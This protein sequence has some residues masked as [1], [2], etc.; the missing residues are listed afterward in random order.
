MST[1]IEWC[2]NQDGT[3]GITWNP[4]TGCTPC[5]PSCQN[6]Y[7]RPMATRLQAMGVKKYAKGFNVT[8]HENV[9]LPK[10]KKPKTIF[11]CSMSDLFHEDVPFEFIRRVFNDI[12]AELLPLSGYEYTGPDHRFIILTKRPGR[13][14][15][16]WNWHKEKYSIYPNGHFINEHDVVPDRRICVGVTVEDQE[17]TSRIR[18]LLQV[19]AE[20]HFVSVEPMLGPIIFEKQWLKIAT[21]GQW[22][23]VVECGKSQSSQYLNWI[24]M[25]A[26][27]GPGRRP[28][29]FEW[30]KD[31]VRQ[32]Q[33][34]NVPLFYKQGPND[35]GHD[36]VKMPILLNRVWDQMPEN[37][38]S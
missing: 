19:S 28:M 27:S 9:F 21:E 29:K 18:D 5:S 16:F 20:M 23:N 6:C 14:L 8:C 38:K 31:I 1:K 36:F 2:K 10:F 24:I 4:V 17:H 22:L 32:C 34:S 13:M 33:L 15:E 37:F 35:N 25:G 26:E 12:R 11:V 7:A 30:A 3:P